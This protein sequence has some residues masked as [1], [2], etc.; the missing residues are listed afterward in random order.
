MAT[1]DKVTSDHLDLEAQRREFWLRP[2][3]WLPCVFL[4]IILWGSAFPAVKTGYNLFAID[5]TSHTAVPSLLLFA[6]SRFSL[7]GLLT[8][9]VT[10]ILD[11]EVRLPKQINWRDIAILSVFQTIL[12]YGLFF[13]SLSNT[14]GATGS[15]LASTSSF[16][17]I[18]LAGWFF[19]ADRFGLTKVWGCILGFGGVVVL[20]LMGGPQNWG[21]SLMGEGFMLISALSTAFGNVISK[22]M[23]ERNHPRLLSGWQ[24]VLGGCILMLIGGVTGGRL[25]ATTPWAWILLLYLAALSSTAFS[26]WTTM[27]KYHSVSKLSIFKS[28]IPIVGT[29]GSGIFLREDVL[30]WRYILALILVISGIIVINIKPTTIKQSVSDQ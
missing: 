15:I 5:S 23:T 20:N 27:L 17:A 10:S 26:L 30:Q 21:F 1:E 29:V 8:L 4:C 6:G 2:Y 12:Q 9:I 18:I 11:R 25:Q 19:P 14:T 3:V 7:A 24:F 16:M 13:I 28:L 22:K